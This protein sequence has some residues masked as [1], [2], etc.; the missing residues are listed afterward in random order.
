MVKGKGEIGLRKRTPEEMA[1]YWSIK[2]AEWLALKAEMLKALEAAEWGG[3]I[4]DDEACPVCYM[5]SYSGHH[6]DCILSAA[7][8]KAKEE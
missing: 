8:K 3:R 2:H 6:P 7:L 5:N 4:Q 1:A